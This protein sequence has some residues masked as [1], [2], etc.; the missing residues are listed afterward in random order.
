M[1]AKIVMIL[2]HYYIYIVQKF[3]FFE[4]SIIF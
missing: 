2:K 1:I 4:N 3:L